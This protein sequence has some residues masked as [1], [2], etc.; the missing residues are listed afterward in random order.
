MPLAATTYYFSSKEDLLEDALRLSAERELEELEE[1]QAKFGGNHLS[2]EGWTRGLARVLAGET[3]GR[4]R[5]T[6]LAQY[7][8]DLQSARRPAL[9]RSV[10][11][12]NEA[13]AR[14]AEPMLRSAGSPTPK[15]DARL[16]V[17]AATGLLLEQLSTPSPRFEPDVF[18]P[19]LLRLA[20][21]LTADGGRAESK[22]PTRAASRLTTGR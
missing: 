20:V 19:G 10:R 6:L 13:Y 12:L 15:A 14:L 22:R 11:H 9:R 17:A 8:V 4:R 3:R 7:E 1:L 16:F 18:A 2:L 21:A 5:T